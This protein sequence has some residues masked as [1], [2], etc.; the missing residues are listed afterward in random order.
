[1]VV[2]TKRYADMRTSS[3]AYAGSIQLALV[4]TFSRPALLL[5]LV[6]IAVP[7]LISRWATRR[8][9]RVGPLGVALQCAAAAFAALALA[10]PA[11][12]LGPGERKC[13]L[14]LQD[15]SSSCR[16]QRDRAIELPP[17]VPVQRL[18]FAS[19][20]AANAADLDPNRTDAS[21]ALRLA[22]A[23][24]GDLAGVVIHT[25]GRFTDHWPPAAEA[26][27]Q[28]RL[29]V[30]IV[31]MD[32]PP[33]DARIADFD[34]R[35]RPDG[36]VG[37]RVTVRSDALYR[38]RLVVR[39]PHP[40]SGPAQTLL[41]RTLDL[42]ADQ[43]LTIALT[44]TPPAGS[45]AAYRAELTPPDIFPENDSAEA[46]TLPIRRTVAAIGL[47]SAEGPPPGGGALAGLQGL[48]V[49]P[50][51]ADQALADVNWWMD[52]SAVVLADATGQLL[53]RPVRAAL[54]QYVRSGGALVLLGA[55]PHGTPADRDDPL[56]LVA[57]LVA[58]PY[59][60]KPLRL[61]VVLDASGSM[62]EASGPAGRVKFAQAVEAVASLR[63]HLTEADSLSVMTFSDDANQVYDSGSGPLDFG[64]L[65][66]ALSK[67]R[68][69]GSTD[70]SKPLN[71]AA[72]QAVPA[73]RDALVL[74]VSDLRTKPFDPRAMADAFGRRG[75]SLAVVA[76]SSAGETAPAEAPPLEALV[77]LL[78]GTLV[79]GQQDLSGLAKVFAGLLR[80]TR[81]DALRRGQFPAAVV[82]PLLGLAVGPL[83][84]VQAY[85]LAAPQDGA[86][87]V[88]QAAGERDGLL[89]V[90]QVGLGRSVTLVMPAGAGL[91]PAW[92]QSGELARVVGQAVR[93]S[94]RPAL[95]GR[96]D[97]QASRRDGRIRVMIEARD[98]NGPVNGLDLAGRIV[99]VAAA[100]GEAAVSFPLVQ[101][102]PGRYEGA[103][104][105]GGTP[106]GVEVMAGGSTERSPQAGSTS[107]PPGGRVVWQDVLAG[108]APAE[109][110]QVGP[111]DVNLARLA[112]LTGGRIVNGPG[113]GDFGQRLAAA[114]RK[115][116][117]PVLLGIAVALMLAEWAVARV[118][119]RT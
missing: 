71:L 117:W 92:E 39:R 12:P 70:V 113:M 28:A 112:E 87:V 43:P 11:A 23:R 6:A 57:A 52:F 80:R 89:A 15:V 72:S 56:N 78:K 33:G 55:G 96:F 68:P 30:A 59:E 48:D 95:D 83:P 98:A 86:E 119:R 20:V 4:I 65:A 114:R 2:G 42:L 14:V 97:G 77:R 106:A 26:L 54:A 38:R 107:S 81:C 111:D 115:D 53:A 8:G 93:W 79:A 45:A 18:A 63:Q 25:D 24:A 61:I 100:P 102:A 91:N 10:G 101:T 41:D 88:A 34:T 108:G 50:V 85:L 29:P 51:R 75:L 1:M 16:V 66:E 110:A 118:R 22:A 82:R 13:V 27:A 47:T 67:V 109:L 104:L 44:D 46:A 32:S 90:R 35:R 31:P 94:L 7:V 40:S 17:D 5:A 37:L 84:E 21:P 60:R 99:P 73:G 36:T 64:A 74:V 69:G 62:A 76:I 105:D 58:N 3:V 103:A 49:Q 19:S 9:H 116:L